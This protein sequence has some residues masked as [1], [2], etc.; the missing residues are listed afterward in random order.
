MKKIFFLSLLTVLGNSL[1]AQKCIEGNCKDGT[2]TYLW[3]N[4]DRYDGEWV[5]ELQAMIDASGAADYFRVIYQ[6]V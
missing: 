5:N 3:E 2:G 6:K 1:Y 4:G